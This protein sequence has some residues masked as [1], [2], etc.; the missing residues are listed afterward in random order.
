M[1]SRL[2]Q[3]ALVAVLVSLTVLMSGCIH[4]DRDVSLHGDGAGTYTLSIGLSDQ[5]MSLS[6]DQIT[7]SMNQFGDKVKQ[8][9]GS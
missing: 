4:L 5:L 9:G 6:S 3:S 1:R 2:R 7:Q 8:Q